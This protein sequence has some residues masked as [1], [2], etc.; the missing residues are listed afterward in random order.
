MDA[1][2][3]EVFNDQLY[4][5]RM[6]PNHDDKEHYKIDVA[7]SF[8]PESYAKAD[9]RL[10]SWVPHGA[11]TLLCVR[12]LAAYA[13]TSFRANIS[14]I[15]LSPTVNCCYL[16]IIVMDVS[17]FTA[18]PLGSPLSSV[19]WKAS[20]LPDLQLALRNLGRPKLRAGYKRIE[21]TCV[22]GFCQSYLFPAGVS[23]LMKAGLRIFAVWGF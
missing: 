7:F 5:E 14:D 19:F 8:A 6:T 17:M 11:L 13:S 10:R 2:V 15:T 20:V 1:G 18:S 21:W 12:L 16:S 9:K 3:F 22:R 4:G 23:R